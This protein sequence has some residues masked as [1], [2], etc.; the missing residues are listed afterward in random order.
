MENIRKYVIFACLLLLICTVYLLIARKTKTIDG[1]TDASVSKL[2]PSIYCVMVTGFNDARVR[3]AKASLENFFQQS[4]VNKKIIIINQSNE[5]IFSKE[6]HNPN[7]IEMMVKRTALG[8]L[9]NIALE[10]VP[11]N[12]IWT[13]WD[14]D[15]WRASK[16]LETLETHLSRDPM[17]K[18]LMYTNRLE[19]NVLTNFTWRVK[20]PSGSYIFFMYNNPSI[21][22]D[23]VAN[24]EDVIIKK[25]ISETNHQTV[26]F[27]NPDYAMYVRFVHGNNTSVY[28]NETKNNLMK[29]KNNSVIETK[30]TINDKKYVNIVKQM[31]Y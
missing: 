25:T 9:R 19:H 18:V 23:N 16:Y 13:T 11:P 1:Y 28:V 2:K 6:K 17:K 21:R 10:L 22:Y 5:T 3:F 20:I 27:N 8:I 12:A 24:K 15:D 4:Y 26:I 7:V 29:Y 31:F 14:D 30:A